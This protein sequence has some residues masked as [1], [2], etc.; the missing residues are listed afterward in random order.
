MCIRQVLHHGAT[1]P[2]PNLYLV[3]V[4]V[5]VTGSCPVAQAGLELSV[6]LLLQPLKCEPLCLVRFIFNQH[7]IVH[8]YEA[9]WC[10]DMPPHM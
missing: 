1:F 4:V 8:M 9:Q 7:T 3:L 5:F 6:I 2:T 10:F